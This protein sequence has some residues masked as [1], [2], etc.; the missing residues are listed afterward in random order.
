MA[1]AMAT[2]SGSTSGLYSAGTSTTSLSAPKKPVL[3]EDAFVLN[4]DAVLL[5]FKTL[6][7]LSN[8][9]NVPVSKIFSIGR[10]SDTSAVNTQDGVGASNLTDL[11]ARIW[12]TTDG[13]V[14][15][16][17]NTTGLAAVINAL[18]E[19]ETRTDKFYYTVKNPNGTLTK[20]F[21]TITLKGDNDKA[22]IT[23][24][25]TGADYCAVEA[26]GV[27]NSL[28]GDP[29]AGGMLIVKDV[30]TGQAKFQVP[31]SLAGNYGTFQFNADTGVW[32]YQLDNTR[33]A[34]QSLHKG[35]E[36]KDKLT[37]KSLD[38]TAK[39][40]IV[41]KIKGTND[42]PVVTGAVTGA[43]V[44][45]GAAVSLN[46]LANASDVDR[47]GDDDHDGDH[48]D[49]DHDRDDDEAGE[50][51]H[52]G[53][54]WVGMGGGLKVVNVP[55]TLPAG[56]T[57]NAA[58]NTFTLDPKVWAYQKLADGE[59]ME[60][61]VLYGISDGYATTPACV[62]WVVTGTNDGVTIT[63]I[64]TEAVGAVTEDVGVNGAGQ[65]TDSGTIAFNDVDLKDIHTTTVTPAGSNTLGGTLSMGTVSESATT[66]DGTVGWTYAVDNSVTQY[67][68]AG[69]TVTERFVVT[70]SDGKG[71][72]AT[73]E[74]VITITGTADN[75]A[76]VIAATI[77]D[78]SS[79]EDESFSFTVPAGTFTDANGDT[80]TYT[81]TLGDDAA[82][83]SWLTFEAATQTFS[84][85]PPLNFNG[86][87]DVKVN[88]SDG[89]FSVSDIFV[90][91]ITPVNDAPEAAPV[92]LTAIVEDS[93]ARLI[94]SAELLAGV[95]DVDGPAATI[96]V[97]TVNT[98]LGALVDNMDGTWT[99]T[100]ASN[101]DT[102][103]TF[104]Y[105]ASDGEFTASS[106][107][108][109]DLT[110]DNDA[111]EAVDDGPVETDEDVDLTAINV[112]GNDTDIDSATL[113]IS[114]TPTALHG[115]VSVNADGTLKYSPN[116]NY[117]GSDTITYV[118]SDGDKTDTGSVAITVNPSPDLTAEDDVFSTDE[119]V[120]LIN[121]SFGDST[122]SGGV[123]NYVLASEPS[124]G[125]VSFNLDGTFTYIPEK[126]RNGQDSFTYTVTD[127]ASGESATKTVTFT[128][129]P[130]ADLVT[131]DEDVTTNEDMP[132][133]NKSLFG[134]TTSG[135]ALEYVLTYDP[136]HGTV[137]I[138]RDGT[139]SYTPHE[140][141]NGQDNFIYKITDVASGESATQTVTITVNPVNDAP[142][143][144]PDEAT[145]N[146]NQSGTIDVL[147]NDFDPDSGDVK[148]IIKILNL[149]V[150]VGGINANGAFTTNG[151]IVSFNPGTR[152]DA[153]DFDD[154][155]TVTF[156]YTMEDDAGEGSES[157][158]TITINGV[159]DAPVAGAPVTASV[160][161]N[162]AAEPVLPVQV[163]LLLDTTDIDA[164]DVLNVVA[165]SFLTVTGP[166]STLTG[167]PDGLTVSAD[168]N[169]LLIDTQ[170]PAFNSLA[171][172]EE[173]VHVVTYQITDGHGGTITQTATVTIKGTNDAPVLTLKMAG[174]IAEDFGDIEGV[175]STSGTLSVADPDNGAAQSF[176]I[177]PQLPIWN[178]GELSAAQVTELQ[179]GFAITPNSEGIETGWIYSVPNTAIDFLNVGDTITLTFDVSV[180]DGDLSDMKTVTITIEG[181][182]DAAIV[183]S[184]TRTLL[185]T[186][187]LVTASGTLTSDDVDNPD[188]VFTPATIGGAHGVFTI[189][190]DGNWEFLANSAFDDLNIGSDPL[191]DIFDVTS[192]DGTQSTVEI[193]I[194]GT[195][196]AP[197][198]GVDG[199]AI[200]TTGFVPVQVDASVMVSDI[201]DSLMSG[202]TVAIS[203][204]GSAG[205]VLAFVAQSGITGSWDAATMTLSLAGSASIA[206]YAQVLSSVTFTT[207]SSIFGDRTVSFAIADAEGL[208]SAPDTA[209]VHVLQDPNDF[210]DLFA[211]LPDA[212]PTDGPDTLNGTDRADTV[213]LL[214]SGDLYYGRAGDDVITGDVTAE[215][216]APAG[217]D[218]IYG[219]AGNDTIDGDGRED[220]LYGG[221]GDDSLIGNGGD[222]TL[223]GGSGNDSLDGGGG[224][225][226]LTGGFGKDIMHG[227][228]GADT[229]KYLS[230][231]DAGDVIGDYKVSDNDVIDL[232]GLLGSLGLN[233]LDVQHLRNDG[234]LVEE[235]GDF[236]TN[237]GNDGVGST[238]LNTQ[239]SFDIDGTGAG[240]AIVLVTLED[241]TGE[242]I[243]V[244]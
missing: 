215:S 234:Y 144:K 241:Y 143:A 138:N 217:A 48:D 85:T 137:E 3:K 71:G 34:T 83:P 12:I 22:T 14:A 151:S 75:V 29:A 146:E 214:G 92:V 197:V 79:P 159:N 188:N 242:I 103:V 77:A 19:G 157:R 6:D 222:D 51:H 28:V 24:K 233:P 39:F 16:D 240:K 152:F 201:D 166:E 203:E 205:D 223:Y 46:A 147:A 112:L 4:E 21:V 97:L 18:R 45:D 72:T 170:S 168:G 47:Y 235:A 220:T 176:S 87:L 213:N 102:N 23:A 184:D 126:N 219:Q 15:Y 207:T 121:K 65:L 119:D 194:K 190:A 140:N 186:N 134:M 74:V 231:V 178:G 196:D 35:E 116:A 175:I 228:G 67:L 195:N 53:E 199:D 99:Y 104:N 141:F 198:I 57:Y 5:S 211:E 161:E 109:L 227:A 52:N 171:Q 133:I 76:P 221:S 179:T 149:T 91:N 2:Y 169:M 208:S 66:E 108:S 62:K 128:V 238:K 232:S 98:G 120:A 40:S 110:P 172:D 210:D 111:P 7:V 69:K 33:A 106:T 125:A 150:D 107:A 60:V 218:F 61:K 142:A 216:A 64:G 63:S 191:V 145:F 244:I 32:S 30:D 236:P 182:N 73:Q 123:L 93:G 229:F 68:A 185:E 183:S 114:G 158:V 163:S 192:V 43:A 202:A 209:I 113:S 94:T 129:D 224:D 78:Q 124:F 54:Y 25:S 26:G 11:G 20:S 9:S 155:A 193:T 36:E 42:A 80:L 89:E 136:F 122:T 88:A 101:D 96:T 239:I 226:V 177:I 38:G 132:L 8:D 153:L 131:S 105:T 58:T 49:D 139:Y 206:A 100:P 86:S 31:A 44:E 180:T 204:G 82:L 167:L 160:V 37:V 55:A 70:I 90:L 1:T 135:G 162:N 189:D 212:G 187:G 95:S 237:T 50:H 173:R 115:T 59:T 230:I 181:T 164:G 174:L 118:V 17:A 84:G 200:T 156:D 165:N 81:A 130:V 13:K 41:V 154:T 56:V 27:N 243:Y 225:D 148:T 10:T 127:A 117:N